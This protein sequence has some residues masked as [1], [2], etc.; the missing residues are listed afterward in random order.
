MTPAY[1]TSVI[2][3]LMEYRYAASWRSHYVGSC[4]DTGN[5]PALQNISIGRCS[6]STPN[7]QA[8]ARPRLTYNAESSLCDRTRLLV[9]PPPALIHRPP[10]II[11]STETAFVLDKVTRYLSW[12]QVSY[13]SKLVDETEAQLSGMV[14]WGID[15]AEVRDRSAFSFVDAATTIERCTHEVSA[16]LGVPPKYLGGLPDAPSDNELQ[17]AFCA[18][19]QPESLTEE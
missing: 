13:E 12:E 6:S 5:E 19:L 11:F 15:W 10:D 7:V 14:V 1:T 9:D 8:I 17:E 4:R 3:Q 18:G 16:A 2:R